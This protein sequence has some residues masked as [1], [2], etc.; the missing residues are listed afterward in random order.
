[1]QP[2]ME[3]LH[4]RPSGKT[5]EPGTGGILQIPP[6][7]EKIQLTQV[8]YH[9]Y[10]SYMDNIHGCMEREEQTLAHRHGIYHTERSG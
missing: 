7:L 2:G 6:M 5:M 9:P 3:Q 8:D 1:M 10:K 4:E